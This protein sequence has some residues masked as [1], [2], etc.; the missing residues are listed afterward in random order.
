MV[1]ADGPAAADQ[2]VAERPRRRGEHQRVEA[3]HRI[4]AEQRGFREVEH[5][6]VGGRW[7]VRG[8]HHPGEAAI[9]A[10]FEAALH[11]LGPLGG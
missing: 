10:R 4:H 5:Q 3:A 7:V 1:P 8:H 11:E 2:H 9:A 6:Q